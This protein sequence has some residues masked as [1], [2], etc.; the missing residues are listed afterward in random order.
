MKLTG[1]DAS[2]KISSLR[3][4]VFSEDLDCDGSISFLIKGSYPRTSCVT[5]RP[6]QT[7]ILRGLVCIGV[8]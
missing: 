6:Y 7:R 3:S 5:H 4:F 8:A 1:S 2:I